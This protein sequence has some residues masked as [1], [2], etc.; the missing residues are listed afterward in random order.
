MATTTK[1]QDYLGRWLGNATPGTTAAT[2]S[3]GRSVIASNKDYL[4]RGLTF[5]NPATWALTTAVTTGAY[6][7]LSGGQLLQA[8]AGGTTAGTEPSASGWTVGATRTD[9]TVTWKRIK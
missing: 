7:R 5:D 8:T 3:D 2:D 9:G 1:L 4:G 6:K